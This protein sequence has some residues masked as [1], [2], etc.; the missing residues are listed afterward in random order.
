[1]NGEIK[2]IPKTDTEFV[3]SI[4]IALSEHYDLYITKN[5]KYWLNIQYCSPENVLV[6]VEHE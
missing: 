5:T 3:G 2:N 1:M 6:E 4:I